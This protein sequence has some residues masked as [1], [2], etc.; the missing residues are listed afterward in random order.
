MNKRFSQIIFSAVV[1][2]AMFLPIFPTTTFAQSDGSTG[3]GTGFGASGRWR[4]FFRQQTVFNNVAG[5]AS[6]TLGGDRYLKLLS[7]YLGV[8]IQVL[9]GQFQVSGM[10]MSQFTVASIV[11]DISGVPLDIILDQ[12]NGGTTLSQ[13]LSNL[14]ANGNSNITINLI[15]LSLKDFEAILADA[16][17]NNDNVG[18][19]E[20]LGVFIFDLN[21]FMVFLSTRFN[22]FQTVLGN[23]AFRAVLIQRLSEETGVSVLELNR[24]FDLISRFIP[25]QTEQFTMMVLLR[26]TLIA[27]DGPFDRVDFNLPM[28]PAMMAELLFSNGIPVDLFIRR[29]AIF[30]RLLAEGF[31]RVRTDTPE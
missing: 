28:T 8:S 24:Q 14:N 12:L 26:G 15:I 22:R 19:P 20:D 17:N 2:F 18:V 1:A 3:T 25:N 7:A 6:A 31:S 5:Q 29:G 23:D 4:S 16:I 9:N 30:Q 27:V 10:T 13:L 11:S 21:R